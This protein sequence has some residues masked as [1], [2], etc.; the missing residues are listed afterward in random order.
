MRVA[1]GTQETQSGMPNLRKHSSPPI[2][3]ASCETVLL[4]DAVSSQDRGGSILSRLRVTLGKLWAD[5]GQIRGKQSRQKRAS[6][7]SQCS[8]TL[9]TRQSG[10]P[11][12][13]SSRCLPT[14]CTGLAVLCSCAATTLAADA[15]SPH[16]LRIVV[17]ATRHTAKSSFLGRLLRLLLV[18]LLWVGLI[19]L[20][21]VLR[22]LGAGLR[23]AR[24]AKQQSDERDRC[25]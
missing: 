2:K 11:A 15:S 17:G 25:G 10:W 23:S 8:R 22:I 24:N 6:Q 14:R 18:L 3:R 1:Q 9:E 21:R 7:P 5:S 20:L 13:H 12:H 16:A 4:D 19:P